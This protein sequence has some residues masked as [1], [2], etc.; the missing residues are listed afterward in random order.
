[1]SNNHYDKLEK[2]VSRTKIALKISL[3][4]QS[5]YKLCAFQLHKIIIISN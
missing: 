1:M 5:L 2:I 3:S 4:I